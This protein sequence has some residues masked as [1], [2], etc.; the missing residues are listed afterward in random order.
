[1]AKPKLKESAADIAKIVAK[2][3]KLEFLTLFGVQNMW[4]FKN[5]T[6]ILIC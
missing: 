1:M 2:I 6:P 3:A 4:I 5:K